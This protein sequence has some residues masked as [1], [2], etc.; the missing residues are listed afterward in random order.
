MVFVVVV[1]DAVLAG[2]ILALYRCSC[3]W[4]AS[5]SYDD[6]LAPENLVPLNGW[7]IG[8]EPATCGTGLS[9]WLHDL[10]A[11]AAHT[12]SVDR[13][14]HLL[15]Y[16]PSLYTT[17][18]RTTLPHNVHPVRKTRR[19]GQA[20]RSVLSPSYAAAAGFP[21]LHQEAMRCT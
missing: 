5:P 1:V 6:D 4:S 15:L 11:L 19:P 9:R 12:E 13:S 10:R 7:R 14:S 16:Q 2:K 18:G 20:I 8:R 21:R 17:K 3:L